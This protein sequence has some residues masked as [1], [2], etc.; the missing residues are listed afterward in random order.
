MASDRFQ[1]TSPVQPAPPQPHQQA[2][3][4]WSSARTHLFRA[5]SNLAEATEE[6]NR[7]E[8]AEREAWEVLENH[9]GRGK[10]RSALSG[11]AISR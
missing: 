8:A 1:G 3:E 5:Q 10:P 7:A 9:A 2:A 11:Q 4:T 6:S